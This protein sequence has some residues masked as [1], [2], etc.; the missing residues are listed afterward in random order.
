MPDLIVPGW[1][2]THTFAFVAGFG[3][4][5]ILAWSLSSGPTRPNRRAGS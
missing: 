2:L 1:V 5:F 3:F 4:A